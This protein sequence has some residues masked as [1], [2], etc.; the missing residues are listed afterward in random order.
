MP[1]FNYTTAAQ[2]RTRLRQL[3]Q[4]ATGRRAVRLSWYIH[5]LNL[6][7]NQLKNLFN[8]NDAQL[9]TVKAKLASLAAKYND[10]ESETGV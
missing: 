4:T 2:F 8:V 6:T 1:S 7:D 3:F 5:S 9:V 10:V